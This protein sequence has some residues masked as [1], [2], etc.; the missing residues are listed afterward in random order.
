MSGALRGDFGRSFWIA[1]PALDLVVEK[2]PATILLTFAGLGVGVLVGI[3]LGALSAIRRYSVLDNVCTVLAMAGQAMPTFWLG[4]LLIMWFALML[5]WLPASGAESPRH[6][7]LPSI[8]LGAFLAPTLMRLTRSQVLDILNQDYVR[9]AWAKGLRERP[10]IV[11]H[12][13]RNAAGPIIT[14]IGLQFGRLLGGSVVTE[15]IFNWPG[16]ASLTVRS[17]TTSDFPVVQ[18]ATLLLAMIVVVS[19][20]LADVIVAFVDPRIRYE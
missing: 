3:P 8:T 1:R 11:G 20:L 19:N 14:V 12:V 4:L 18:V 2:M 16:V 6:L 13:L 17:I 10:I 9:T 15:T 7:I 5:R